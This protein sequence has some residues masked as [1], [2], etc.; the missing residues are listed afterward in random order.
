MKLIIIEIKID[1]RW[2]R[3]ELDEY[4]EFFR[5]SINRISGL[6]VRDIGLV[7]PSPR[8]AKLAQQAGFNDVVTAANASDAAMLQA[9]QQ[10]RA[11][12]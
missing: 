11:G 6:N 4:V 2:I 9:L 1:E 10:W 7:V 5:R 8:V 12:D 3:R